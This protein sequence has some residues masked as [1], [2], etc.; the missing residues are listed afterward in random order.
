M[1]NVMNA[2]CGHFSVLFS[3]IGFNAEQSIN[4]YSYN[5]TY[6]WD[7]INSL[8]VVLSEQMYNTPITCMHTK[9]SRFIRT[10]KG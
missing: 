2:Y 7:I 4:Q 3:V 5:S 10:R 1:C 6:L 9:T 8:F